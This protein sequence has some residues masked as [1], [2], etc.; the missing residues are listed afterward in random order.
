VSK[1]LGI[2]FVREDDAKDVRTWSGIPYYMA[3]Y[4]GLVADVQLVSPL[5]P[6]PESIRR[7]VWYLKKLG[8]P[9][10]H[11][12]TWSKITGMWYARQVAQS[13]HRDT[14]VIFS[15]GHI[16]I[17]D[18]NTKIPK[19]FHADATYGQMLGFYP[20]WNSNVEVMQDGDRMQRQ[21][22]KSCARAVYSSTWAANYALEHYDAS[23][24]KV[25]SI[26][27]GANIE[28]APSRHEACKH[29]R[30]SIIRLLFVGKDWKRKGGDIA[31]AI[32]NELSTMGKPVELAVCG[33]RL[34]SDAH[35][36]FPVTVY[37]YLDKS[38]PEDRTTL[39]RLY[40]NSDF[41]L[42]P[43]RA[44]CTP[45]VC[46][47]AMAYGLPILST[48]VGGLSSLVFD[49]LNGF[50][51]AVDADASA[52]AQKI[53]ALNESE[54]HHLRRAARDLYEERFNWQVWA[55]KINSECMRLLG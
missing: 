11:V 1:Q 47:E 2:A 3:K 42:V 40:L 8:V 22:F 7:V 13:L 17:A 41:L 19:V 32:A 5:R 43:S 20:G 14:D 15:P 35:C 45:I 37:P 25:K 38:K 50:T 26:P 9:I 29:Q 34:P 39:D 49:G 6:V 33:S 44:D 27:Y 46:C 54:Y 18:L 30:D 55:Q 48:N 51:F 28:L 23:L 16:P 31:L 21:A 10:T 53:I 4:L 36:E 52:Y 12:N 24:E